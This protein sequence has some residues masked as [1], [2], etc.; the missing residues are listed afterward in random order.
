MSLLIK[1]LR[2]IKFKII[3]KLRSWIFD[4]RI[5]LD[6]NQILETELRLLNGNLQRTETLFMKKMI[7]IEK[8]IQKI[9][10]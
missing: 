10:E 6:R 4:Y 9:E 7:E 2:R 8:R 3:L 1:I 5:P